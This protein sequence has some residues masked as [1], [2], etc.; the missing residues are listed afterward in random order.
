MKQALIEGATLLADNNMFE[1]GHGKLNILKSIKIL[2]TY[3]PKVT[4]SPSYLDLTDEYMWPYNTQSIYYTMQPTIINVT[5]LN[6][7]G[8]T[9]KVVE[10]PKW[11]PY[12][13]ENG[14]L[15]NVSISY[16]NVL[17]PWSGW[18]SIHIA[19]NEFGQYFEGI[20]QGHITLTVQS[21][22]EDPDD[23]H[24]TINSTVSF[25]IRC[26][27]I[28]K[29]PRHKRILWDQFH[30]LRY[31]PGYLPKDNLKIKSD[32]L[33]WRSDHI[34]TNFKDMYT[35]LRNSGYY[36][37]VLGQ[38]YTC[39]NASN[40]GTLLLVDPEEEYFAEEIRKLKYDILEHNL[41]LIVFADWYNTTV[42]KQMKF[43]DQNTRQWWIPDTGGSNLPALNELLSEFDIELGDI[44]NDGYFTMGD[45]EMFY[46]SGSSITKFPKNN[47]T[48]LIEQDLIDQGHDLIQQ[49][50]P[51]SQNANNHHE[52]DINA[53]SNG[54]KLKHKAVILGLLQTHFSSLEE[55]FNSNLHRK[56]G[57]IAVFGDSNCLDSTH[58]EKPC[59]WLLDTLLE[60]TMTSHVTNLLKN[61]NKSPS[62][63]FPGEF[64]F[65]LKFN[66]KLTKNENVSISFQINRWWSD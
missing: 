35:H 53:N 22:S 38:P 33:D 50:S 11:Y 46:A 62:I 17:W 59:F 58:L 63:S 31:P 45:L 21:P 39:F 36:I 5:I 20:A 3:Q 57:R 48:I 7:M 19:V 2:S 32:P 51:S 25:S 28:P 10:E 14:N 34:H 37:E 41:S 30:N 24:E 23:K 29:P 42:M 52:N 18:M 47:Q 44:V 60:Y 27:I 54:K 56:S 15:L 66:R 6:G 16:S 40:Y 9:G 64:L 26:K 8:V 12:N 49:P 43:Y 4:L 61:L 1:Q 13:N 65:L 55:N